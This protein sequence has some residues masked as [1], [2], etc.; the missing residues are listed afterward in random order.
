MDPSAYMLADGMSNGDA[1][2]EFVG[3][4]Q[5]LSGAV[6]TADM[7]SVGPS[8]GAGAEMAAAGG[9]AEAKSGIYGNG[10]RVGGG[11]GAKSAMQISP[12]YQAFRA[13]YEEKSY[14]HDLK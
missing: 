14:R 11:G 10:M 6:Y 4:Y 9:I 3:G 2:H 13:E 5:A 1:K 12:K 8:F 7:K